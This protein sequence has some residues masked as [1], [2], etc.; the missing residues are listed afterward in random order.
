[1]IVLKGMEAKGIFRI[2]GV[3]SDVNDLGVLFLKDN[4]KHS[5]EKVRKG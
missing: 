4:V 3:A 1:M 5:L 2:S